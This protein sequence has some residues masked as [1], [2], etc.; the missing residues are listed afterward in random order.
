M[1]HSC[2]SPAALTTLAEH[3]PKFGGWRWSS[4]ERR[5]LLLAMLSACGLAIVSAS[6]AHTARGRDEGHQIFLDHPDMLLPRWTAGGPS[7]WTIVGPPYGASVTLIGADGSFAPRN[8]GPGVSLWVYDLDAGRMLIDGQHPWQLRLDDDALPIATSLLDVD[9]LRVETTYFASW[10]GADL[11]PWFAERGAGAEQAVTFLRVRVG[12][13]ADRPR[14]VAAYMALRPFGVEPDM[15]AISSVTCD[16][17]TSTLVADDAI[18]LVGLQPAA[19]CGAGS[20]AQDEVSSLAVHNSLPP[21]TTAVDPAR[22]AEAVIR[23]DLTVAPDAPGALEF[24]VPLDAR[25]VRSSVVAALTAGEFDNER[26]KVASTWRSALGPASLEVPDQRLTAAFRASQVY[27]L[28]NRRGDLPRSGPLAHDAF[29]VRDAAYIGEA[30][31]RLGAAR[32]NQATLEAMLATQ[33]VDGS[34]PAVTDA[35]GPRDVDEWDAP[36]QSIVSVVNH[37]RFTG[38]RSWLE[39]AYSKLSRAAWF[40]DALRGRTLGEGPETRSLLPPNVSAED[41]GAA[42][43]HHYWDDLWAIAGYREAAFA[44]SELGRTED[45]AAFA[46]RADDLQV[47]LL[48]S[49]DLV[50]MRTGLNFVPNGPEDVQS[51]AMA[52]GT[53]PALWPIRSLLG[54]AANDLLGRSFREYYALWLAPQDGGYRHYQGTL[55]PYGGLGIAHAML[56][57]GMV[58]QTQRVLAWTIDHQTLPGTYAWGEAI[59]PQHGGLELGDMPHSWAAAEMI[60]LLR[61]MLLS[62]DG[63]WLVVNAGAPDSWFDPGT[64]VALRNAATQYG[65]ATVELTRASADGT[66]APDLR[67]VLDGNPPNGWRV[68]LPGAPTSVLVDGEARLL[69][70]GAALLVGPGPHVAL[71]NCSATGS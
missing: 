37:Y 5:R 19:A 9:D 65:T 71:L 42:N 8:H 41:I 62:E 61:D 53:T 35:A 10:P 69:E 22:R 26:G 13:T 17:A 50:S 21:T 48:R 58:E 31:E 66:S 39:R 12:T 52:R 64:T 51:S 59:N 56:R 49:V 70:S 46:R 54:P 63:G 14:H 16:A 68:R 55:W 60:S 7:T 4:R 2:C 25:P 38:D 11:T 40:I 43:W 30:L 28:L 20:L 29:W 6:T 18:V 3:L 44:G 36:G 32:D 27:L 23:Y 15:H 57:L 24:R 1:T 34:F 45:A 47:T 67:V 33:R